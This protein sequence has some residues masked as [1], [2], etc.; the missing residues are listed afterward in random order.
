MYVNLFAKIYT[1]L[2]NFINNAGQGGPHHT[3]NLTPNNAQ[4]IR[5]QPIAV[6]SIPVDEI[7]EITKNFSNSA[8]IGEGSYAR[9]FFGTLKDGKGSIIKKLDDT[10]QPNQEFLAQVVIIAI[11]LLV[12]N[13]ICVFFFL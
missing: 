8:L 6:P 7:R 1:S 3:P 2:T 10:K 12:L 4:P 11:D 13:Q 5:V 9:V